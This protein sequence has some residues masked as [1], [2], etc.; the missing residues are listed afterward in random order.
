LIA[1]LKESRT[2]GH[3]VNGKAL[4]LD[5]QHIDKTATFKASSGWLV[6]FKARHELHQ[7]RDFIWAEAAQGRRPETGQ[8]P[9]I[10]V[11]CTPLTEIPTE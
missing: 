2:E 1:W 4:Q 8:F 5:A 3:A 6:S 9:C 10:C 11:E 7:T